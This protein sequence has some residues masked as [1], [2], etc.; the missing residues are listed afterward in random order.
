MTQA[1][2]AGRA[3]DLVK[4]LSRTQ[5]FAGSAEEAEARQLCRTELESSGFSCVDAPFEYSQWPGRW[6]IPAAAAAQA[7]TII[8]VARIAVYRGPLV[9]LISGAVLY[10]LLLF[11][12]ADVNRRWI[13]AFPLQRASA[14]NLQA[15]RG[16]PKVWLIAHLDSKSQSVAML[17]RIASSIAL[18]M[19]TIVTVVAL[20]L[21]LSDNVNL[22][23]FWLPLQL[24][25]LVAAV[26]SIFCWVRNKSPGAVDNASGVAAVIMAAQM[27]IGVRNL[28]VLITSG[29][30][31]GLAGA[32]AWARDARSDIV[33]IN[34]DTIDDKGKWR[35]M[36]SNTRPPRIA[37]AAQ[38]ISLSKRVELPLRSFVPG[39]LADSMALSDRRIEAVTLSRGT[40][41]TLARIHTR[42]D[43]SNAF[44]GVGVQQAS[45]LLAALTTELS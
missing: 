13:L 9:A 11:V 17:V 32:R 31:L 33:A 38:A 28:G 16:K 40:L 6:G 26:P 36:Y 7:A 25:T 4:R 10:V 34:C 19:A 5:R 44:T 15:S 39:I 22:D 27:S 1:E 42:R 12:A 20:L 29:E 24:V 18:G 2:L 8:S 21:S 45:A 35:L 23:A 43:N 37:A 3:T 14:T 41:A 30:E